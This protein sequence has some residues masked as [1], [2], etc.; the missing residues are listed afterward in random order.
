[1]SEELQFPFKDQCQYMES[2]YTKKIYEI[3]L[4]ENVREPAYYRDVLSVIRNCSE[5]DLVK[6]IICNGGGRLDSA[7]MFINAFAECRGEVLAVLEGETHSAASMIALSAHGVHVK[8]YASMM[9]HHASFGSFNTVQNVVDHVNFTSKQTEKLVRQ[10]YRHFLTEDEI[11]QVLRNREIWL[12]DEEIGER[13]DRMYAMR[14]EDEEGCECGE[15]EEGGGF[16]LDAIIDQR[17]E[18]R[19]LAKSLK[20]VVDTSEQED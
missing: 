14:A 6:V 18:K 2:S 16:N 1:M 12:V 19:V 10:V 3:V 11:D 8:P 13:L 17:I 15:C 20:K 4:D 7:I 9:I 5:G